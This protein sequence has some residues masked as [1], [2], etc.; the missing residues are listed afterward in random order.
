[1]VNVGL[2][3]LDRVMVQVPLTLSARAL[4]VADVVTDVAIVR[5]FDDPEIAAI[6]ASH[7]D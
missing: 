4:H 6:E 3:T 7:M 5:R 1:M 2:V